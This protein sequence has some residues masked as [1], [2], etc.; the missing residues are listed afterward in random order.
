M[1]NHHQDEQD[2]ARPRVCRAKHRVQVAQEEEDGP[3]KADSDKRPVQRRQRTPAD[4]R[5]GDPDQVRVA[6][7]R[8]ALDEVGARTAEPAQCP[9]QRNGQHP[10]I[11]VDET[12]GARQQAEVILEVLVVLARQVLRHGARQEEDDDDRRRDPERS[13]QVRVAIQHV[14]EVGP[15]VQRRRAPA[16]HLVRVDVKV[17]RV[18]VDRPPSV[19][20][21]P[22]VLSSSAAARRTSAA[23]TIAAT[24]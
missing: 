11:S 1:Q 9:P 21:E 12:R 3:A 15:R 23:A 10:R 13:V 24:A 19:L 14:E 5:D 2:L 8:P 16:Q 18:V 20:G 6:V 4:E 7:Q 22:S 17:L